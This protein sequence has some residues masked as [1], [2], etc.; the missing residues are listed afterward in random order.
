MR[1]NPRVESVFDFCYEDFELAEY[2]CHPRIVAPIA[3]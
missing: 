1:L 3:V 2:R